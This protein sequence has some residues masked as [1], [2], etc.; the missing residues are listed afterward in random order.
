MLDAVQGWDT[1]VKGTIFK[2]RFVQGAQ[3]PRI[4]GQGHIDWGHINPA[5]CIQRPNPK[6]KHGIWYPMPEL[7]IT[8]PYIPLRQSR[9]YPLV[10]DLGFNF[11]W[12]YSFDTGTILL[13]KSHVL[14]ISGL[15]LN[16]K[17][18]SQA[19]ISANMNLFA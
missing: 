4:F 9:L 17:T 3:H 8:S 6:K 13:E 19:P 5:S 11:R 15:R 12:E 16:K 14:Q 2:G 1:L 10:R 7:T 18:L